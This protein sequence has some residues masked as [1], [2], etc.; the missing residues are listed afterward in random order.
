MVLHFM[1]LCFFEDLYI[2]FLALQQGHVPAGGLQNQHSTHSSQAQI[3]LCVQKRSLNHSQK[4]KQLNLDEYFRIRIL[5][6]QDS[7]KIKISEQFRCCRQHTISL[8]EMAECSVVGSV[9]PCGVTSA[10]GGIPHLPTDNICWNSNRC[11]ASVSLAG[12]FLVTA[13]V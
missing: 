13:D 11:F 9:D 6:C 8:R 7:G 3:V 1:A 2:S 10:K 12:L 4:T 5:A